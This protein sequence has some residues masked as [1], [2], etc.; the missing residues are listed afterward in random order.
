MPRPIV[1]LG[2]VLLLLLPLL[3]PPVARAAGLPAGFEDKQVARLSR[4]TGIAFTPDGRLLITQQTGQ[5]RVVKQDTLVPQAALDLGKSGTNVVCTSYERG[6]LGIAVD[7]EFARTSFVYLFYTSCVAG[8]AATN[9]VVR[10]TMV[11]DAFDSSSQFVL[12]DNIEGTGNYHQAGGMQFG[13]DGYLYIGTG[14]NHAQQGRLAP[15][16]SSL[17]GKILRLDRATGRGVAGNPFF[18]TANARRCGTPAGLPPGD[19]PCE[20][21]FA[22]GLRNPFRIAMKPGS[23]EFFINDVGQLTWE[24]V[25]RGQAGTDYGWPSR[26][27]ACPSSGLCVGDAIRQDPTLLFYYYHRATGGIFAG[28]CTSITAAAFVPPGVWPQEYSGDYLFA[29]YS[30]GRIYRLKQE[31]DGKYRASEFLGQRGENSVVDM[32]FGP[33]V[34]GR[35]A[36]YYVNYNG[37]IKR[38]RYTGSVNRPPEASLSATPMTGRLP[39]TVVFDG[40][41]STDPDG[42]SLAYSWSFGDGTPE[43]TTSTPLVTHTY[44]LSGTFQASLT[45]RDPAGAAATSEPLMLTPGNLAPTATIEPPNLGAGYRV[46]QT[47][48]LRGAGSDPEDGQLAGSKLTWDVRLHHDA[49]THPFL[50]ETAGSE[51][52]ITTVGPED[53]AAVRSSYLEV[54][55]VATDSRGFQSEVAV[56]ELRPQVVTVT[57]ESEPAALFLCINGADRQTPAVVASWPNYRLDVTAAGQL[58]GAGQRLIMTGWRDQQGGSRRIVTPAADATYRAFFQPA[59]TNLFLPASLR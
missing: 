50:E 32:A 11:G 33:D 54:R 39:L 35:Q 20:E 58:D 25:N 12:L 8:R 26:E 10:Y 15:L 28:G 48:T 46:G 49:H 45:V 5:V 24:E 29:D 18:G 51:L 57:L 41:G 14:D 27:G 59:T 31:A 6:L 42:D 56:A 40:S 37:Q 53:L 21:I 22:W 13:A 44:S 52:T 38:I 47:I 2:F 34:P 1:L 9:R 3:P 7:P 55:L 19:G 30:C 17:N 16:Q 4:T 43:Q 36:L 23:S